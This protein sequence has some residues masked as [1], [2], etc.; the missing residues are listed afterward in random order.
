MAE[1]IEA[2][3]AALIVNAEGKIFLMKSP[4]WRDYYTLPGG[5]VNYG[6][7]LENAVKREVKEETNLDVTDVR[8]VCFEEMI[9]DP[10]FYEK[11]HF[12]SARYVC[13]AVSKDV[14]LN[15]EG[16]S[17]IWVTPGEALRI[18]ITPYTKNTIN[19]WTKKYGG[20]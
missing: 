4:K 3:V 8:P 2:V 10:D 16:T 13:R 1:E 20:K 7:R 5:H 14:K 12:L 18:R 17:F 19:E 11:K 15:S 9:F 6:E